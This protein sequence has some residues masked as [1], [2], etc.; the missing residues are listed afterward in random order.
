[1][2]RT[3]LALR[4]ALIWCDEVMH[5]VVLDKPTTI[6]IGHVGK[7]TFIVPELGLPREFAIIRPGNRG[8]LLTLGD[9]MRG[10]VCIDG[11]E[12][13]VAEF[14]ARGDGHNGE[15]VG[16]FRAAQVSGKDW[17]VIELDESGDYKLFFQFVTVEDAQ[18]FFTKQVIAAGVAGYLVSTLVLGLINYLKLTDLDYTLF[19]SDTLMKVAES[20]FRGAIFTTAALALASLGYAIAR[21]DEGAQVSLGFSVLLHA[22]FL[23]A[24]F[25]LYQ[26]GNDWVYPGSRE[27][28]GTYLVTRLEPE[29]PPEPAKPVAGA[30]KEQTAAAATPEKPKNTATKNDEGAAGGKGEKERARDPNAKDVPPAPPKVALFEGKNVK[31]ID[32]IINH[33]LD[34]S[35][36][37]FTGIKGDTLTRGD[38]GFGPGGGTGVGAGTGTGTTRGSK[39]HG[40]GGGGDAQGDFVTNKGKID[41][42]GNRPGGGN[43][44]N[45]PCGT[46]MKEVKLTTSG[47]E[48]DFGGLTEEEIKRVIMARAGLFKACYQKELNRNP[49]LGGTLKMQFVISGDGTVKSA[50]NAGGSTLKNDEVESCVNSNLMRLKFPAKGGTSNVKWPFV[51]SQGGG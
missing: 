38:L 42:G 35:L 33:N 20:L 8:Y 34:T 50:R 30:K 40:N 10:T 18:P 23:V 6:T 4:T 51:Y 9:R 16:G 28:T 11:K 44:A 45:P 17:G 3:S 43:C 24:T 46:G 36:S 14:V 31:T 21:Q 41:T 1:M 27:L 25:K 12:T 39:G 32:N 13:K 29:Q 22:A 2:K 48:G 49:G 5:D 7:P 26:G 19:G 15:L 47:P 37:K